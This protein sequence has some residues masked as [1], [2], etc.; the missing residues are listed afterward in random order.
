MSTVGGWAATAPVAPFPPP[1]VRLLGRT[2]QGGRAFVR[3]W[4]SS[5][6]HAPALE[7]AISTGPI[8][9]ASIDG[10]PVPLKASDRRGE[11]KFIYW[12]LPVTGI[13]VTLSV[14]AGS[15]VQLAVHDISYGL[16]NIPG[17]LY[18][19]RPGDT[20]SGIAFAGDATMVTHTVMLPA[21]PPLT[22]ATAV[23]RRPPSRSVVAVPEHP[24]C[25]VRAELPQ[26]LRER[27]RRRDDQA[28]VA[29]LLSCG[30]AVG[31]AH[32]FRNLCGKRKTSAR[33]A[34]VQISGRM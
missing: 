17:H 32:R 8:S 31:N 3:L 23:A 10:Q 25:R 2:D 4:L 7:A 30:S 22:R 13:P 15:A 16:P 29:R 20:M 9:A 34:G 18:K 14:P 24:C 19:P 6:R 26:P 33:S 27:A 1:T 12:A 5:P 11:L 21:Q 28:R